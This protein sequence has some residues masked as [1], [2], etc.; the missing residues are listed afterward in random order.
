[1]RQ[2]YRQINVRPSRNDVHV[3]YEPIDAAR[4]QGPAEDVDRPPRA[5]LSDGRSRRH[6]ATS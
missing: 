4:W 1:M 2:Q 3:T 5:G 6:A